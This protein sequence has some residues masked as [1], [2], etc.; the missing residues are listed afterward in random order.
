MNCITNVI[1]I[2]AQKGLMEDFATL[3]LEV[4]KSN[5]EESSRI[6]VK[7]IID[8]LVKNILHLD[9]RL[10]NGKVKFFDFLYF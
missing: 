6:A 1:E 4:F 8:G 9:S 7:E 10:A 5:T 3:L 2:C